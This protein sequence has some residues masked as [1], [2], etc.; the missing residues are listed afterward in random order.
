[1]KALHLISAIAVC[2]V[3]ATAHAQV[4]FTAG[5][6]AP[7]TGQ[8]PWWGP[9]SQNNEKSRS[10]QSVRSVVGKVIAVQAD[11]YII[12]TDIQSIYY[13]RINPQAQIAR[14]T[15]EARDPGDS[16]GFQTLTS[17]SRQPIEPS[18][19]KVGD[20]IFAEGH[21]SAANDRMTALHLVKLDPQHARLMQMEQLAYGKTWLE[22][23]LIS[24]RTDDAKVRGPLDFA[25]LGFAIDGNTTFARSGVPIAKTDLHKGEFVRVNGNL[26]HGKFVAST[27]NILF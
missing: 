7:I 19:I 22:G 1:M 17:W 6:P 8:Y 21:T 2:T 24:L 25:S 15:A 13:V 9:S 23:Q 18:E 26:I 3:L 16:R 20:D 10:V 11:T 14:E 12:R 27:V 4:S 5:T